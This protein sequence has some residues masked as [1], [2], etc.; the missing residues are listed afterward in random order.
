MGMTFKSEYAR[1][2]YFLWLGKR[3]KWETMLRE[4]EE[5][6]DPMRV[7]ICQTWKDVAQ[8]AVVVFAP[9]IE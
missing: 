9:I 3:D 5:K 4:A 6:G 1:R 8:A 7:Q 2:Q